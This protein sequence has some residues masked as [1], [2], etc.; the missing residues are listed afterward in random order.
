MRR[1][2]STVQTLATLGSWCWARR[3]ST[4]RCTSSTAALS[5]SINLVAPT[6]W[7]MRRRQT[8][9]VTLCWQLCRYVH[10]NLR[11]SRGL[12]C[13][14]SSRGL[15]RSERFFAFWTNVSRVNKHP[16]DIALIRTGGNDA[17]CIYRWVAFWFNSHREQH[18]VGVCVLHVCSSIASLR[19]ESLDF[20]SPSRV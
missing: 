19:H 2:G 13:M 3:L 4:R 7:A 8:S 14:C 17:S 15:Q 5:R 20:A 10:A 9:P 18:F 6:S 12:S 16:P 1:A 11:P